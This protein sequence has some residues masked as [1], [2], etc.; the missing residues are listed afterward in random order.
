[1]LC[2]Q[3]AFSLTM[4]TAAALA[5][6]CTDDVPGAAMPGEPAISSSSTPSPSALAWLVDVLPN[7]AELSRAVGQSVDLGGPAPSIGDLTD[8]RNTL[9]VV[10]KLSEAECHGVVAPLE[11]RTYRDAPVR[12]VTYA[13][14][15]EATYGAVLFSS[16]ESANAM[17]TSMSEQ[18]QQCAGRTVVNSSG[19]YPVNDLIEEVEVAPDVLSA[20]I[21]LTSDAP[22]GIPVRTARAIGL[23]ADC[24]LEAELFVAGNT[25]GSAFTAEKTVE[26]VRTMMAKVLA[27]PK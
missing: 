11:E 14:E 15:P 17:F 3:V 2:K 10:S 4:L 13:T 7:E 27:A 8:L 1:M 23:A 25:A 19:D 12:A 18:W 22:T 21:L 5:T 9:P 16:A 6:S 24:I 26:L 20:E